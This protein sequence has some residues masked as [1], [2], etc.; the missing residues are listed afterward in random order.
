MT[1]YTGIS[2]FIFWM[3]P[4]L[5]TRK[6]S[7]SL[8]KYFQS[9]KKY[10]NAI[11]LYKNSIGI[12]P[13]FYPAYPRLADCLTAIG[14][15][16]ESSAVRDLFHKKIN[17]TP[18]EILQSSAFPSLPELSAM[19]LIGHIEAEASKSFVAGHMQEASAQWKIEHLIR[20]SY[21]KYFGLPLDDLA[22]LDHDWTVRIGHIAHIDIFVKAK[23]LGLLPEKTLEIVIE[24]EAP[25]AN[26]ELLR[27]W[28]KYLPMHVH[29]EEAREFYSKYRLLKKKLG[30]LEL[31][32]G[33]ADTPFFLC[34]K[35]EREWLAKGHPPLLTLSSEHES[36]GRDYL[37]KSGLKSSDWYVAL[38]VRE[39]GFHGD[40]KGRDA[41]NSN[42]ETYIKAIKKIT[43]MGGWVIRLGDPLMKPLPRME[44]VIDYAFSPDKSQALDVFLPVKS[45]F[46][47]CTNSGPCCVAAI[48]GTPILVT[49]CYP[50]TVRPWYACCTYMPKLMTKLSGGHVPLSEMI[51]PPLAYLE[52]TATLQELGI[53]LID[54]TE[55]E[56]LDAVLEMLDPSSVRQDPDLQRRFNEQ[57]DPNGYFGLEKVSTAFLERHRLLVKNG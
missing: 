25:V 48:F 34:G 8:G 55:D 20:R 5:L 50:L 41:R 14:N 23:I 9:H 3:V 16:K 21:A 28:E 11:W 22:I 32:N 29:T 47:L 57:I 45:R 1:I 33:E 18:S 37:A 31:T 17:Y 6:M 52:N 35:M 53:Q 56:I 30:R 19:E 7:W 49:N 27:Y 43:E 13:E 2:R 54:N 24:P 26:K 46:F 42:I 36:T 40:G 10:D 44:R 39:G 12:D 38:H 15:K 4:S 51:R